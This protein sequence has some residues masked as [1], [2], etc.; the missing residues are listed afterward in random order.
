MNKLTHEE[1]IKEI[2]G[3]II[4]NTQLVTWRRLARFYTL[5]NTTLS[6]NSAFSCEWSHH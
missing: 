4:P 6:I 2:Q 1:I 3:S 5:L